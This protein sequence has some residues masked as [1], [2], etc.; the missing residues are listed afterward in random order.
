MDIRSILAPERTHCSVVAA[1]KKKAIE[2][3]SR[4]IAE[5][6]NLDSESIYESLITRERLG[7]T[8][9]GHGIAI[10]HCRLDGCPSIIGS[11]FRLESPVDFDSF[12]DEPVQLLF[13]LLVPS[14]EV[15]E[16]LKA[17]GALA[18]RFESA[19][20]RNRLLQAENDEALFDAAVDAFNDAKQA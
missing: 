4:R 1:S 16:H 7:T 17:L 14:D 12:D 19:E 20:Y 11:L 10:P 13:V 15:D 8:A 18:T 6:A 5:A 9:I 2:E 3:A